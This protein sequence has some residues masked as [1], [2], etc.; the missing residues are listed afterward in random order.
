ML[1]HKKVSTLYAMSD[2]LAKT[3]RP[4]LHMHFNNHADELIEDSTIHIPHPFNYTLAELAEWS[5]ENTDNFVMVNEM[6][7]DFIS[8]T[9]KRMTQTEFLYAEFNSSGF[10]SY[11]N[12]V[13]KIPDINKLVQYAIQIDQERLEYIYKNANNMFE[14]SDEIYFVK[15]SISKAMFFQQNYKFKCDAVTKLYADTFSLRNDMTIINKRNEGENSYYKYN[16]RTRS[17]GEILRM[18]S[19]PNRAKIAKDDREYIFPTYSNNRPSGDCFHLWNGFQAFDIDLKVDTEYGDRAVEIKKTLHNHLCQYPWY[20]S[21]QLS[22]SGRALHIFT[23]VSAM[24]HLFVVPEDNESVSKFWYKVNYMQK[25]AVIRYLLINACDVDV[26]KYNKV[27]KDSLFDHSLNKATQ[28][29]ALS[30]DPNILTNDNFV[31]HYPIVYLHKPPFKGLSL[32]EWMICPEVV[33]TFKNDLSEF[34]RMGRK[35]HTDTDDKIEY[36]VGSIPE[37]LQGIKQIDILGLDKGSRFLTRICVCNTV[38]KEFGDTDRARDLIHHMLQTDETDTYSEVNSIIRHSVIRQDRTSHVSEPA[39]VKMLKGLGVSID[40]TEESEEIINKGLVDKVKDT[41][42]IM[43]FPISKPTYNKIINLESKE[44]LTDKKDVLIGALNKYKLN[45]LLSAP[46]TG[47]TE[48]FKHLSKKSTVCLVVP[49]TS[50]IKSK[51]DSD[52]DI[53]KNFDLYYDNITTKNLTAGRSAVMTFDKFSNLSDAQLRMFSFIVVD[54]SHLLHTSSY[55]LKVTGKV[56][57][58]I[59][60]YVNDELKSE[61]NA[62]GVF[63]AFYGTT[64]NTNP[65]IIYMTGTITGEADYYAQYDMLNFIKIERKHPFRKHANIV[66]CRSNEDKNYHIANEMARCITSG[67]KV[68]HPTNNGDK[69]AVSIAA[70]VSNILGREVKSIYYKRANALDKEVMDINSMCTT[71]ELELLMCTEYLSVGVDILDPEQFKIMYDN[72]FTAQDIEQF[73][74]RIRKADINCNVYYPVLDKSGEVNNT[75]FNTSQ[76]DYDL[77]N[78]LENILKDDETSAKLYQNISND[79]KYCLTLGKVVSRYFHLNES[80]TLKYCKAAFELDTFEKQFKN[81]A[82]GLLYIKTALNVLFGYSVDLHVAT[83]CD[84]TK[85]KDIDEAS[86][87]AVEEYNIQRSKYFVDALKFC[88]SDD[89]FKPLLIKEVKFEETGDS[90][91]LDDS[92]TEA[93]V[94]YGKQYRTVVRSAKYYGMLMRRYYT[95]E[96]VDKILSSFTNAKGKFDFTEYERYMYMMKI[97]VSDDKSDLSIYTKT[98]INIIH[99]YINGK[100]EVTTV[101]YEM[102]FG[103][104]TKDMYTHIKNITEEAI[105]SEYREKNIETIITN[106]LSVVVKKRKGKEKVKVSIRQILPF[107]DPKMLER[108]AYDETLYL[109]FDGDKYLTRNPSTKGELSVIHVAKKETGMG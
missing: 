15:N 37:D 29:I 10:D 23:K 97:I 38:I 22:S 83:D 44:Y 8:T 56:T 101:E 7:Q 1:K 34:V 63:D 70:K 84:E 78:E 46:G 89:V 75:I 93:L 36:V 27:G 88:V 74:N 104:M 79:N 14:Y 54:E 6:Y 96:T 4:D 21:C 59:R 99:K 72:S 24:H 106:L 91:V 17:L 31:E 51:I 109:F 62:F 19:D 86:K 60:K 85:L 33:N 82:S 18:V 102:M 66:L 100:T 57:E 77:T 41:L 94:M 90:L 5:E 92:T 98:L 43:E 64:G 73:N 20:V 81:M 55:R 35:E 30:Y 95:E 47:K 105:Y 53:K 67:K 61:E 13:N 9:L 16:V 48:L 58:N 49:F 76:V 107:N 12:E 45:L 42:E 71:G 28:G 11:D 40:V 87:E 39:T 68:I 25:F 26:D 2:S 80:G 65:Y 69:Y 32:D 50:V 52:E 108:V 3:E 103:E